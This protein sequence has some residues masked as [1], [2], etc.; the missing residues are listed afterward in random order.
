M[1][2]ISSMMAF[3]HVA[4]NFGFCQMIFHA[5]HSGRCFAVV[6]VVVF[7]CFLFFCFLLTWPL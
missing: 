3:L 2:T 6:V 5:V 1:T 7:V 4:V